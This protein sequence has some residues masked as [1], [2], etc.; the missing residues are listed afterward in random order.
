MKLFDIVARQVFG[1]AILGCAALSFAFP[2]AF[3]EWG[4]VKLT[5][6]VAPAIQLIMFGMG[7]TLSLN[8]FLR[9]AKCPW[10]VAAGVSLQFLIMPVVG[11]LLAKAF[12]F[13]ASSP[14]DAY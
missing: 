2:A 9:V 3:K 10:A 13:P 4:G 11:F 8:D 7:T 12:G 14:Q 5:S 1:I 6:C